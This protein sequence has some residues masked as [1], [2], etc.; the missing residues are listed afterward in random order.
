[1][2]VLDGTDVNSTVMEIEAPALPSVGLVIAAACTDSPYGK[3]FHAFRSSFVKV[4]EKV[5]LKEKRM[6]GSEWNL[7]SISPQ[8][9]LRQLFPPPIQ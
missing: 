3:E 9:S 6:R 4:E 5:K 1:M 7:L 8:P 2:C